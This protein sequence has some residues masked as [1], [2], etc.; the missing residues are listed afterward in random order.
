V[1]VCCPSGGHGKSERAASGIPI[2]IVVG[3]SRDESDGASP[4]ERRVR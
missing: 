4:A 3:S 1:L 2:G